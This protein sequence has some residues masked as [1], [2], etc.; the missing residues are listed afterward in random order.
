MKR[1][2]LLVA[3]LGLAACNDPIATRATGGA[4]L[5]QIIDA[6]PPGADPSICWGK[7][8]SPAEIETVTRKILIQPAQVSTD[9]RIQAPPVYRDETRQEIIVPRRE[10]WFETPCAQDLT[11]EFIASVQRAL[12]ARDYY[13]GPVTSVM[14]T[15]TRT[16]IRRFQVDQGL[17]SGILSVAAAQKLGLWAIDRPDST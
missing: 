9:G 11:P 1:I 12:I 4:Q 13:S 10:Q 16:A 15:R 6:P 2:S 8:V 7:T 14:D 3:A 17:D 5:T